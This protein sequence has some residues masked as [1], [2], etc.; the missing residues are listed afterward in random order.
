M[1]GIH[2]DECQHVFKEGAESNQHFLDS[3]K[4]LLKEKR[5]PLMLNLSGVPQLAKHIK[6][7]EQLDSLL[8]K[9]EFQGID[10]NRQ[11]DMDELVDLSFSY[12]RRAGVSFR[13]WKAVTSSKGLPSLHA[14]GGGWQSSC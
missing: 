9:V 5:W 13:S 14:T 2:F 1:I 3:F 10:L 12:A 6:M 8:K 7:E 11:A 4:T